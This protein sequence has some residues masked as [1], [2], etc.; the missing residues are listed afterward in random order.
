[1]ILCVKNIR[2]CIY[3]LYFLLL[4]GCKYNNQNDSSQLLSDNFIQIKC[5]LPEEIHN[6]LLNNKDQWEEV[7]VKDFKHIDLKEEECPMYTKGD[8]NHNG[9]EDFAL[10]VRNKNY[11]IAEFQNHCF[12]FL[13][14]FNDYQ[15][16]ETQNPVVIYKTGDYENE[17]IKTVIYDQ[18]EEGIL[19][20]LETER[21]CDKE[22]IKIKIPEKSTFYVYWNEQ[23]NQYYYLNHLDHNLCDKINIKKSKDEIYIQNETL[24]INH[25]NNRLEYPSLIINAMALSTSLNIINPNEFNLTYEYSASSTKRKVIYKYSFYNDRL[26]LNYKEVNSFGPLGVQSNRIYLKE[27]IVKN[28]G[29]EE[30][31][32]LGENISD[33]IYQ[34]LDSKSFTTLFGEEKQKVGILKQNISCEERFV[35]IPFLENSQIL[36]ISDLSELN[37]IAYY[38]TESRAYKEAIFLLEQIIEQYPDRVVA[39]L[40]LADAQWGFDDKEEAKN[41]YNTYISLMK[42]QGKDLSRIP[43]R[44]YERIK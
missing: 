15:N 37:D 35:S 40:N 6:Y 4:I 23:S 27:Y 17:T 12:P 3:L 16:K 29:I 43:K 8:F 32:A 18:F 39:Y 42:S 10:I 14:V 34:D 19:S 20:Y 31:E 28:Q 33:E 11:K 9:K 38:L 44:V 30:L 22:V 2:F 13:L 24:I 36:E 5:D 25:D 26:Y 1:M 21:I 41:N 7:S